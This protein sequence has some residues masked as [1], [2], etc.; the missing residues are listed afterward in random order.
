MNTST[1]SWK[2]RVYGLQALGDGCDQPRFCSP[3]CGHDCTLEDHD[4]AQGYARLLAAKLGGAA[5]GWGADVYENLGWHWGAK[6]PASGVTVVRNTRRSYWAQI[7]VDERQYQ[8]T[9]SSA[10]RA[11]DMLVRQMADHADALKGRILTLYSKS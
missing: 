5:A 8:F 6:H 11:V 1:L 9:A 7:V 3:A 4:K 2:P 10:K